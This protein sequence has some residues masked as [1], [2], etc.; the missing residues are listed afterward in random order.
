MV[1]KR[2]VLQVATLIILQQTQICLGQGEDGAIRVRVGRCDSADT[3][4]S[5]HGG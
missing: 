4:C 5:V 2:C 1:Y 3:L